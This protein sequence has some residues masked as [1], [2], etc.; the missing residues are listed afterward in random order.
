MDEVTRLKAV[1]WRRWESLCLQLVSLGDQ[2]NRRDVVEH[3]GGECLSVMLARIDTV[4]QDEARGIRGAVH[5]IDRILFRAEFMDSLRTGTAAYARAQQQKIAPFIRKDSLW[6]GTLVGLSAPSI[7]GDFVFPASAKNEQFPRPGVVTL[8]VIVKGDQRNGDDLGID[9]KIRRLK[10]Q[11]PK[12]DIV[13]VTSTTGVVAPAPPPTPAEEAALFQ[14]MLLNY[15]KLPATLIVM[16]R[17][18]TRIADPDRRRIDQ[19]TALETQTGW[20][21]STDSGQAIL[22]DRTGNIVDV[23][24]LRSTRDD[25]LSAM[26]QGVEEQTATVK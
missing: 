22:V 15:A 24:F 21:L 10:Q 23:L 12:L 16:T 7:H 2:E 18:F 25:E 6:R 26:V 9:A 14:E 20:S 4:S 17:P 19:R 1:G 13:L 3:V 8:F 5:G 11:F